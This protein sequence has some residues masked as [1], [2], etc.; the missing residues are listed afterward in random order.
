MISA[1]R[2]LTMATLTARAAGIPR[3]YQMQRHAS[4]GGFVGEELAQLEEGPGMPLVALFVANRYPFSNPTQVFESQCLARDESFEYQGLRDTVIDVFLKAALTA[5]ILAQ[6]A[7][8]VLRVD[9]LQPL[10]PGVVALASL[11]HLSITKRLALAIGGEIDD[12][13]VYA[14]RVAHSLRFARCCAAL[15]DVQVVHATLPDQISPANCPS[16]VDQHL[17]LARAEQQT[18]DDAPI[19]RI[20]RDA[21]K[22]HQTV[23]AGVITDAASRAKTRAGIMVLCLHR[24]DGLN[25]FGSG[26]DGQLRTEAEVQTRLAVDAMVRGVGIGDALIPTYLCNPG[27]S[28]IE[29]ALRQCQRRFMA[30]NV[31]FD[32]NGADESFVHTSA[33]SR[34]QA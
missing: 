15:G 19:Q 2:L 18:A 4:P 1:I 33:F 24:L 22:T 10:A 14:Q 32:A 5:R 6:T 13:Q 28:L 25:G 30:V 9:L 8:G 17:M 7:F 29:G 12:A 16:V 31:Q 3:V 20:E 11:L 27:S 21:I 34:K 23:G 26:A